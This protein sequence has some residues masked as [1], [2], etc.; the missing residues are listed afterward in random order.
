MLRNLWWLVFI[1]GLVAL[2]VGNVIV[3]LFGMYR[4][5]W[6]HMWVYKKNLP[7]AERTQLIALLVRVVK[8]TARFR[9]AIFLTIIGVVL[10][11]LLTIAIILAR[12]GS[13]G[14]TEVPPP[15]QTPP[16][17]ESSYKIVNPQTLPSSEGSYQLVNSLV[18]ANGHLSH[19]HTFLLNQ[20]TGDIWEMTCRK[21]KTVEFRSVPRINQEEPLGI[22][23]QT[24]QE[25]ASKD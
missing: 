19:S 15:P 13:A 22:S 4:L 25:N 20:R 18:H 17:S 9:V 7:K 11:A 23:R 2:W 8:R 5:I 12:A 10:G 1:L 14:V 6:G 16:P 3:T 24:A 21:G